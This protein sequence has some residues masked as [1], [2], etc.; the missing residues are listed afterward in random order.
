VTAGNALSREPASLE[1]AKPF[2]GLNGI[3]GAGWLKPANRWKQRRNKLTITFYKAYQNNLHNN[4][5]ECSAFL[6]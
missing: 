5:S 4:A 2:D 3:A 6:L 1:W